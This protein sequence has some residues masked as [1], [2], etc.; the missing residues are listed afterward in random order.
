MIV[1]NDG[2]A[3]RLLMALLYLLEEKLTTQGPAKHSRSFCG[4]LFDS[5]HGARTRWCFFSQTNTE[6]LKLTQS[7]SPS[8]L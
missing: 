6:T 1:L 3:T 4:K 5:Q 8:V 7:F 2:K